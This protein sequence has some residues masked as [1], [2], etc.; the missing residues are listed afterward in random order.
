MLWRF[1]A[2]AS[3]PFA[4]DTV[5]TFDVL[6]RAMLYPSMQRLCLPRVVYLEPARTCAVGTKEQTKTKKIACHSVLRPGNPK[7]LIT[8]L[9]PGIFST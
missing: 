1:L 4:V 5:L 7:D 6:A 2:F 3:F 9:R 8:P